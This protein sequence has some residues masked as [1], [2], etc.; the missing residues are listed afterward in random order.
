MSVFDER[1]EYQKNPTVGEPEYGDFTPFYVTV[2]VCTIL[3]VFLFILNIAFGC[4][5]R[6]S[7]YWN[8]RH[9]GKFCGN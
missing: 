8:E 7:E 4:C 9:T 3:G 5:S 6:Y 1:F 2:T